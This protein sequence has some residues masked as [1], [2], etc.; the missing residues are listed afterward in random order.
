LGKG[1]EVEFMSPTK[2]SFLGMPGSMIRYN[3]G[4]FVGFDYSIEADSLKAVVPNP[5][6]GDITLYWTRPSDLNVVNYNVYRSTTRNGFDDGLATLLDTIPVGTETYT[7]F[8]A[9]ISE[10]QY[11]YIIVPLNITNVEGASTYSIGIWTEEFLSQ[12]DTFGIPLKMK[13]NHTADWYCAEIPDSVGINYFNISLQLWFWHSTRMPK[14][15]FDPILVMTEGYQIS[16]SNT[17]K[18]TFIGI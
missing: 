7:D 1:Y 17:T 16:T 18:F 6:T 8:G 10:G 9:A 14:G 4:S 12:Y 2:Y 11:Y 15:A 3:S 5:V 13:E